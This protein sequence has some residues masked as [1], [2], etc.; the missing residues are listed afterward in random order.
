MEGGRERET[1]HEVALPAETSVGALMEMLRRLSRAR[2]AAESFRV[3][4]E[5]YGRIRPVA[6]FVGVEPV[7]G[8]EGQF[9]IVYNV[10]VD[11]VLAGRE[12]P[13]RLAEP[14][15]GSALPVR[16]GGFLA[17]VTRG[18]EPR[19]FTDLRLDD[20]LVS[21]LLGSERAAQMRSCFAMPVVDGPEELEWV[22][23]FSRFGGPFTPYHLEQATLTANFMSATQ[24]HLASLEEI[25][26]LHAVL[27]EQFRAVAEVQQ[28]L[29]PERT[30]RI[31]G[32]EIAT[33]YL[34]SDQAGGD[35]YDFFDMGPGRWGVMIADV[36]GHGAAAATLM[37]LLRGILHAHLA[38]GGSERATPDSVLAYVNRRLVEVR[39][40]GNFVTAFLAQIEPA[41]GTLRYSNA[42]HN[43]PRLKRGTTGEVRA[44]DDAASLPLGVDGQACYARATLTL[45]PQD[46]IV[47]YT[48]GITEQ[49]DSSR[50]MFGTARL[51]AALHACSG[52]PDCVIENVHAALF[53]HTGVSRRSDDQTLV[54]V[55]YV[56]AGAS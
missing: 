24:R 34:P 54:A 17:R 55:R 20:P 29:L 45:A 12:S 37:S 47:L 22:V 21:E 32:L 1:V 33:S 19:L 46:T 39:M 36:S 51:D 42:G 31:P 18:H 50:R 16:Q 40:G 2:S 27:S 6:H 38:D 13:R 56:G 44:L 8:R 11:E 4:M 10:C 52:V 49:F 9:R 28:A 53:R 43:P 3:F 35:Y 14:G 5:Q 15:A 23:A 7:R 25:R 30:P 48:D 41:T 26:R